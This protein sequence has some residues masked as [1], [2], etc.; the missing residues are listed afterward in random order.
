MRLTKP[1]IAFVAL[2]PFA[3]S[4]W[5]GRALSDSVAMD[6]AEDLAEAAESI[7]PIEA[8]EQLPLTGDLGIGDEAP[9]VLPYFDPAAHAARSR[10][11]EPRAAYR[12]PASPKA[13]QVAPRGGILV[14][15]AAV[16]RA[17]EAG[18]RPAG[19]PV[20][21]S[22]RRPAGMALLGV[23]AHG[24]GLHDGDVLTEIAGVAATSEGAVVGAIAGAVKARA[25][26]VTGTVWRRDQRLS[27]AVQIPEVEPARK[28]PSPGARAGGSVRDQ[29][30][31]PGPGGEQR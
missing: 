8:P 1:Q 2:V 15:R 30:A 28:R 31:E 10:A 20:P 18:A 16:L 13:A 21:A 3:A 23:G 5:F 29:A 4:P 7:R 11:P 27:L 9:I 26:V 24:A 12:A 6:T 22:G 14:T 25:P 19:T 17:I